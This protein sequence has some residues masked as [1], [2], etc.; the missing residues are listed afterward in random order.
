MFHVQLYYERASK[1]SEQTT[2]ENQ[3]L[4]ASN[5]ELK[6]KVQDLQVNLYMIN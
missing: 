6:E 1:R 4:L 5:D 3:Q 2:E